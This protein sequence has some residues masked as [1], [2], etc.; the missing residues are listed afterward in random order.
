LVVDDIFQTFDDERTASGLKALA[1]TAG[2]FQTI[3]FTHE[4]SVVEIAKR[5]IGAELDLILL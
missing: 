1:G 5:E 2:R 4:A 3:L